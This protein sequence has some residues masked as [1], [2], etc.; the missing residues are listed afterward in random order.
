MPCARCPRSLLLLLLLPP[1]PMPMAF[2]QVRPGRVLQ[3]KTRPEKRAKLEA[4]QNQARRALE[5]GASV[6][7]AAGEFRALGFGVG[8]NPGFGARLL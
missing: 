7:P 2:S 8:G 4:Q 3:L 5:W 6:C 1:M